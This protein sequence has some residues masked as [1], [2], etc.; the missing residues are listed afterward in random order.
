MPPL[1]KH[2]LPSSAFSGWLG[3]TAWALSQLAITLAARARR[4]SC[5]LKPRA[6][7]MRSRT[8]RSMV[9]MAPCL[10]F[11]PTSSLSKQQYTETQPF[12]FAERN[13]SSEA[14]A[15]MRSSSRGAET[16]CLPLPKYA[17]LPSSP[18]KH[19]DRR[20]ARDQRRVRPQ[21]TRRT[22]PP[23]RSGEKSGQASTCLSGANPLLTSRFIWMAT[24][25]IR[26]TGRLISR[27]TGGFRYESR[28]AP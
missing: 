27:T 3:C 8:S 7:F 10:V 6:S 26:A 4:R 14:C 23:K 28:H 18:G 24:L 22:N 11:D 15:H 5:Q 2:L 25:G 20:S 16:N 1:R 13:A 19:R 21:E 9:D 12:C 17:Q